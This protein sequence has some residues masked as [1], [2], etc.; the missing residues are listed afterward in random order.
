MKYRDLIK[1]VQDYSGFSDSESEEAL[2]L[3]VE[4]LASRLNEG[5][6]ED[7][8][9]QLPEELEDVALAPTA[10]Q[11]FSAEDMFEELSELQNIDESRAKKQVMAVWRALKEALSPGEIEDIRA[12]LPNDLADA[13]Y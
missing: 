2:E 12:Q 13:L 1:K 9:S 10:T 7:L 8:A 3:V 11:K 6:R 5:E 4:T